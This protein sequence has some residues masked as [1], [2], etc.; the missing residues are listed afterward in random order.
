M[1]VHVSEVLNCAEDMARYL[2]GERRDR[3]A[4]HSQKSGVGDTETFLPY[5]PDTKERVYR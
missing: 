5:D 2:R 4:G 3:N 1:S